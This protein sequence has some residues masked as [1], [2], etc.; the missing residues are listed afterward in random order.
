MEEQKLEQST[1]NQNQENSMST[2]VKKFDKDVEL[3][4]QYAKQ[5][6]HESYAWFME[7]VNKENMGAGAMLFGMTN[8]SNLTIHLMASFVKELEVPQ[9]IKDNI[10]NDCMLS[11]DDILKKYGYKVVKDTPIIVPASV[12]MPGGLK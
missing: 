1:T 5:A 2:E 11:L 4:F 12:V 9:E 8:F 7:R 10:I 6:V 3:A